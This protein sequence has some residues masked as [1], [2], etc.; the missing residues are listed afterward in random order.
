[1]SPQSHQTVE[2]HFA[3]LKDPRS[4]NATLHVLLDILVI[5]LCATICGAEGWTEFEIWG[6]AHETWLRTFLE[7]PNGIPSHDTFGRVFARLDPKQFRRCFLSWVK[8]ISGSKAVLWTNSPMAKSWPWTA[9][10]CATRKIVLTAS[11]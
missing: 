5:A 7:L 9:R 10:N 6:R 11:P 2:K 4:G 3:P 1:M 8:A